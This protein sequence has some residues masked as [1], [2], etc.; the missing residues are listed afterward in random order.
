[1]V[2]DWLPGGF[3]R[4]QHAMLDFAGLYQIDALELIGYDPESDTFKSRAYSN[5]SPE[6]LPHEHAASATDAPDLVD[7]RSFGRSPTR[8]PSCWFDTPRYAP[9]FAARV[10]DSSQS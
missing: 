2:I 7:A 3:F 1:V 5:L 4:R 8:T 6:P 9:F 10:E